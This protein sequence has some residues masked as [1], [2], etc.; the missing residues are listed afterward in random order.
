[1]SE[2]E[3][4]GRVQDF[5][6]AQ[7]DPLLVVAARHH[8]RIWRAPF[9]DGGETVW[10]GAGT[11]DI[12]FEKDQRNGHLTHKIDPVTD[13]ERDYIGQSFAQSGMVVKE[14]YL[15]SMHAIKEAHTATG[16]GFTSDGHTLVIYL[17]SDARK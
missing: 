17:Q 13:G 9:T 10:V 12:G 3:L 1:M 7:G 6:Y 2:L 14:E 5:G 8:F 15:T 11:H 16:G 4:F